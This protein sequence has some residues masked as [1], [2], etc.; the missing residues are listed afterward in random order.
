[1]SRLLGAELPDDLFRW[2]SGGLEANAEKIIL[3]CTVDENGL[4]HPA[5]LSVLEV[6][7]KDPRTIRLAPYKDSGT[8]NN[9]RRNGKL[10]IMILDE[11]LAYYIKGSVEELQREMRCSHDISK[12]NMKVE[13]VI[14]DQANEQIE[15]G[16]YVAGAAIYKDPNLAT[17]ILNA[18]EVLREL[19]E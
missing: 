10:T 15:A 14:A 1:M 2:L 12:L 11:R 18:R 13:A 6:I 3:V 5:M 4:P 8:T 17:R 7:A 9:M 19:L 16:V